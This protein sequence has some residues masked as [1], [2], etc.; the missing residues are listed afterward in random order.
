VT[1]PLPD[2]MPE[3]PSNGP[4]DAAA[5]ASG[6]VSRPTSNATAAAASLCRHPAEHGSA[7]MFLSFF[8]HS[9]DDIH[10]KFYRDSA[11]LSQPLP[12]IAGSTKPSASAI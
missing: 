5:T 8:L 11:T 10:R 7:R 4:A 6:T 9:A 3:R 12:K 2:H 1:V